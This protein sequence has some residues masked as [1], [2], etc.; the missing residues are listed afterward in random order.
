M[1][2][3]DSTYVFSKDVS[4]TA[5]PSTPVTKAPLRICNMV[6]PATK[7]A[8]IQQRKI[9]LL[10]DPI[11]EMTSAD[12]HCLIISEELDPH[13]KSKTYGK[14]MRVVSRVKGIEQNDD[15]IVLDHLT[16]DQVCL[17]ARNIGV[18]NL[19]SKN[20]FVCHLAMASHFE[21]QHQLSSFG[22]SPTARANQKTANVCRAVNVILSNQFIEELKKVN[23]RKSRADHKSRNTRKHFWIQAAMVYNN[24]QDDD[25]V[26]N[27][28]TEH[29]AVVIPE[30]NKSTMEDEFATL[31]ISYEDPVLADLDT[32]EEVDLAQFE[33]METNA[34]QK[35]CL[36]LF[37]VRSIMKENMTKSRTHDSDP[38]NFIE[39][40]MR[41]FTGLT[42]ISV[43]YF[44]KRCDE[45]P[46]IDS[47]F[48]LFMNDDLKGNSITLGTCD[49]DNTS[50]STLGSTS[51]T[52]LFDQMDMMVQQ[53]SQLLELLKTSVEEQKLER[54]DRKQEW[55]DCD[56][57]STI[58]SQ[59]KIA[60]ALGDHDEL[61]HL[62]NELKQSLKEHNMT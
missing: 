16:T 43:F 17:F 9:K 34:F 45:H 5:K 24:R 56:K 22:L 35:K 6:T 3:D 1:A 57:R 7:P 59:I 29:T 39:V 13:S 42:P 31:T 33:Q 19:G 61:Q 26:D 4:E 28:S 32:N 60:K 11:A 51:K 30:D 27:R 46:D 58:N 36:D 44:Y 47:V 49:D 41:G 20:K 14:S 18:P 52:V 38:Y 12:S 54:L 10:P 48:Q 62:S 37:K 40:A 55:M 2:E 8:A 15:D 50:P 23:D 25:V 53:G 21:F